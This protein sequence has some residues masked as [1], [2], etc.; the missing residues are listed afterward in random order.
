[1]RLPFFLPLSLSVSLPPPRFPSISQSSKGPTGTASVLFLRR[2]AVRSTRT[3]RSR[4]SRTCTR[5]ASDPLVFELRDAF[6]VP[7]KSF[8]RRARRKVSQFHG[9]GVHMRSRARARARN[10]D[11]D[12]FY[13]IPLR[14]DSFRISR[15]IHGDRE[16][17]NRHPPGT[18]LGNNMAGNERP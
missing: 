1:M 18:P 3:A 10:D 7:L 9:C 5:S 4:L 12:V 13:G 17:P 16:Q 11:D 2:I 6:V 14:F 8:A 15:A